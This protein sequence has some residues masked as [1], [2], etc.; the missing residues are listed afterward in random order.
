MSEYAGYFDAGGHP[1]NQPSVA[2]AGFIATAEQWL[3]FET[4]WNAALKKYDLGGAFH[5]T[6]FEAQKRNNRGKILDDLT[7][8]INEHTTAHFSCVVEM[9]PY[10]KVNEI[11]ALEETIGTPYSI[12]TR[13]VI[14]NINLWKRRAFQESD[15][16]LIFVEEGTKHHGDMEEAFRRDTLPVPERVPKTR[17][18]VQAADMLVWEVRQ[19]SLRHDNRR[20]LLRLVNSGRP[21]PSDHG[22]FGEKELTSSCREFPVPRRKD[23]PQNAQI[24]Y[25][26]SPKRPRR[27]TIK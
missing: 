10:R 9:G 22:T 15:N 5:M 13:G 3:R 25:H 19:F 23:L 7:D 12:A 6:D 11:Y 20:S 17:P 8:I 18:P 2:V 26:S 21:T 16:F 24:V 27:R 4:P 14:R 1:D